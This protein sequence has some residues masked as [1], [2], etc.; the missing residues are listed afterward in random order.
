MGVVPFDSNSHV[1]SISVVI[2]HKILSLWWTKPVSRSNLTPNL[3][4]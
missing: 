2:A 4:P 1:E 3:A